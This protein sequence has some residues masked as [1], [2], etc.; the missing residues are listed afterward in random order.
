MLPAWQVAPAGQRECGLRLG[1]AGDREAL[2]T[3]HLARQHLDAFKEFM[4]MGAG[5][6]IASLSDML[7]VN[8]AVQVPKVDYWRPRV[9]QESLQRA[10]GTRVAHV[11]MGFRGMVNGRAAIM[12]DS[13][14]AEA[15][16][17]RALGESTVSEEDTV[18]AMEEI[19]NLALNALLGS[20]ASLIGSELVYAVPHFCQTTETSPLFAGHQPEAFAR[21]R[22]RWMS[23]SGP[24][25]GELILVVGCQVPPLLIEALDSVL[26]DD[27]LQRFLLPGELVVAQRPAVWTTVLGSCVS[28]C[29]SHQQ[30]L[31]AGMNHYLLASSEGYGPR[32]DLGRFGDTSIRSMWG[33][34]RQADP[35]PH[36]Y[37]ARIF[38]GAKMFDFQTFDIGLRNIEVARTHLAELGI[39]IIESQVGGQSG[40][41][42]RFETATDR[43]ECRRHAAA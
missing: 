24:L 37:H 33:R 17:Q 34:L 36:H 18:S 39:P 16:A 40:V 35:N 3:V 32:D 41:H 15:M 8:G 30:R 20:L 6:A 14:L 2:L 38:G 9:A 26:A 19:A 27:P 1:S 25:P 13:R 28:V 31:L 22:I 43:V 29:V 5:R 23:S 42:L 7:D 11:V 10:L 21:T 4:N 12:F